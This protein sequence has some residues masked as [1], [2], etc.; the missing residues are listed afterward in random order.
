MTSQTLLDRVRSLVTASPYSYT[1]TPTPFDFTRVPSQDET[2]AV[3]VV[4][5]TVR[6]LGGHG[7]TEEVYDDI[8]L[9]VLRRIGGDTGETA[10]GLWDTAQSLTS[11]ML[12]DATA[13]DYAVTDEGRQAEVDVPAG[14][15]YAVLRLTVPVSYMQSL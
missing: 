10:R 11:A 2:D 13:G 8:E 9:E 3:R 1:E 14:A 4:T 7:Y 15:S 5:R 12:R 6:V